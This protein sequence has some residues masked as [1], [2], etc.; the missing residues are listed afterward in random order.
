MKR[1]IVL[2]TRKI[3]SKPS[4]VGFH[5]GSML[6]FVGVMYGTFPQ[7]A[8]TAELL[9]IG[10]SML[11]KPIWTSCFCLPNWLPESEWQWWQVAEG[12]EQQVQEGFQSDG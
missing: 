1:P 8:E 5:R 3:L 6:V 12:P 2:K 11:S 7:I 4:I 9:S 10:A